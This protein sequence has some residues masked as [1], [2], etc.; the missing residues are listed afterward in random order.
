M[1]VILQ[2]LEFFPTKI[3]T[4]TSLFRHRISRQ[5]T[6]SCSHNDIGVR[7]RRL[8]CETVSLGEQ[9]PTCRHTVMP[10]SSGWSTASAQSRLLDLPAL[11][12]RSEAAIRLVVKYFQ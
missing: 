4:L 9:Y 6:I 10:T 2:L 7:S 11:T 8:G 5:F 1:V 3:Q 12:H